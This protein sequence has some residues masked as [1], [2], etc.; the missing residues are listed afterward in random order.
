VKTY[1]L[2][3]SQVLPLTLDQAWRFFSDPRNLATIT[4]DSLG[5]EIL[6]DLPASVYTGLII[7]YRVKPLLGIPV[8]WVTEITAVDAPHRFVDDQRVGPYRL[9]HHEHDFTEVP[10]G[11]LMRDLV[12]YAMPYGPLGRLVHWLVVQRSLK[13]IFTYRHERLDR[14]FSS[15]I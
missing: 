4:P 14:L 8:T 5:F 11:V 6:S 15:P 9:W 10:G 3:T 13:R 1:R 12:W 7:E 2:E